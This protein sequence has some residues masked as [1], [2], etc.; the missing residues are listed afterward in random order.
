MGHPKVRPVPKNV[1]NENEQNFQMAENYNDIISNNE[2]TASTCNNTV[3]KHTP[4]R[5]PPINGHRNSFARRK[6]SIDS[7]ASL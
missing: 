6:T 4:I 7:L 1:K 5:L 3:P 2:S